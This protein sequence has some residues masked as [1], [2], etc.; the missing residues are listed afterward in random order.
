MAIWKNIKQPFLINVFMQSG[1]EDMLTHEKLAMKEWN[2]KFMKQPALTNEDNDSSAESSPIISIESESNSIFSI[3]SHRKTRKHGR[4][5]RSSLYQSTKAVAAILPRRKSTSCLILDQETKLMRLS[6]RKSIKD[7]FE[8]L[9]S[10]PLWED[11]KSQFFYARTQGGF[12]TRM[13]FLRMWTVYALTD[14][15]KLYT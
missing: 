6:N 9:H 13:E 15:E 4:L 11:V 3:E 1:W 14:N 7:L 2:K 8:D 12:N 5:R 10:P